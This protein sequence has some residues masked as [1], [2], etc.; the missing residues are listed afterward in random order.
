MTLSPLDA[1][2]ILVWNRLQMC[3]LACLIENGL[4]V[5]FDPAPNSLQ[6]A[7]KDGTVFKFQQLSKERRLYVCEVMTVSD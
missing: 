1:M 7:L 5:T 2:C 6:V 3:S 4:E